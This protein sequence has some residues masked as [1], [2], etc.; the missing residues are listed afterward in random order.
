MSP[1][2]GPDTDPA[3]GGAHGQ[4]TARLRAQH[5]HETSALQLAVDRLTAVVGRPAFVAALGAAITL[6]VVGN[7]AIAGLGL[8]PPDPPPFSWLQAAASVGALLVAALILTT[9]RREDQLANHSAHL[10]LELSILNDQKT[11]KIIELLEEGRR[12][13]P[14]LSDRIDGQADAMSTPS[15]THAVLEAIKESTDVL[16]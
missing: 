4:A 12:D 5:K 14:A 10:I 3:A 9:Q 16:A 1:A 11:S 15:D 6:W 8:R 2:A 7:L 13:N